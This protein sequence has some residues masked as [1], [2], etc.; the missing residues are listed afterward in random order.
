[1]ADNPDL[2]E[3]ERKALAQLKEFKHPKGP[4]VPMSASFRARMA[5]ATVDPDEKPVQ[6]DPAA[7]DHWVIIRP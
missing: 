5:S 4:K 3:V 2:T 6:D 1:M 7:D